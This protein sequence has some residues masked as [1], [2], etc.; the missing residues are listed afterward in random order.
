[1]KMIKIVAI[2]GLM[3]L[4]VQINAQTVKENGVALRFT[5]ILGAGGGDS[6]LQTNQ[7]V[8]YSHY[9]FS[10]VFQPRHLLGIIGDNYQRLQMKFSSIKKSS[11]NP[12]EYIV[13]GQSKVNNNICNFTGKIVIEKIQEAIRIRHGVDDK[14]KGKY[15]V[16][17]LV[18]AKYIFYEDSTQKSAGVFSGVLQSLWYL[19]NAKRM[20]YD[21]MFDFS[22]RYYN[23]AFVGTWQAYGRNKKKNCNF[24]DYRIPFIKADFD[25]GAEGFSPNPKYKNNG[26]QKYGS[27]EDEW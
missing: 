22:D 5:N 12:V 23:N 6:L 10:D 1:M 7:I 8:R 24:G 19:D 14:Y 15:V 27:L 3:L 21:D 11:K 25:I 18:T 20:K 16:S 9:D 4:S 17:G 2:V 26:W 13:R